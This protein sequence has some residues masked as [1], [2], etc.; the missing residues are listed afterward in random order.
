[1]EI[2]TFG[3]ASEINDLHQAVGQFIVYRN[4]L[5]EVEPEREL[6][7]AVPERVR[8]SL[9]TEG[10]GALILTREIHRLIS[11]DVDQETIVQWLPENHTKG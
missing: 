8:L 2:K 6:Y 1:M 5:Q 7:L 11:Y 9:F 4:V 3:G 10:V